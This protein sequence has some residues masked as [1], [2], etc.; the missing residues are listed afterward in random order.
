MNLGIGIPV[1]TANFVD[2]CLNVKF[3]SENGLLG[4]G[5]YPLKGEED[6]DLTNASGEPIKI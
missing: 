3:H 5:S 6:P 4:I 2:P 1:L